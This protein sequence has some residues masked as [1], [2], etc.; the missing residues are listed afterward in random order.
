MALWLMAILLTVTGCDP[1]ELINKKVP[2][3]LK[4]VMADGKGA[5]K[6]GKSGLSESL[7]K[8]SIAIVT[9][10]RNSVHPMA[11]DIEFEAKVTIPK[12]KGAP[13]AT[14]VWTLYRGAVKKGVQIGRG[15]FIKKK[16]DAGKYR[17]SAT[18]LVKDRKKV[19]TSTFR[20]ANTT[21]GRITDHDGGPF[22]GTELVITEIDKT[23]PLFTA[24]SDK[25]GRFSIEVPE[26]GYYKL[27]PKK[28]GFSFQP[29]SRVVK[30]TDPPIQQNFKAVKG[31]ITSIKFTEDPEGETSLDAVCPLQQSYVTFSV[32]SDVK[33]KSVTVYLVRVQEGKEQSIQ[34]DDVSDNPSLK[35]E[36][37]PEDT[38]LKLQVPSV[39]AVGPN[40]TTYRLRLTVQDEKGRQFSAEASEPLAYN[41]MKCFRLTL[42]NGVSQQGNDELEDAIKSYKLME[43]LNKKV[44]D[45]T[46]FITFMEQSTFNRGLAFLALAMKEKPDSIERDSMLKRAKDDFDRVLEND[47][48]DLDAKLFLGL[49]FQLAGRQDYA[50]RYYKTIIEQEP[51]YPG[52]RELRALA[53]LKY[54]E[55]QQKQI[56]KAFRAAEKEGMRELLGRLAQVTMLTTSE[57]EVLKRG[58]SSIIE[59]V[60]VLLKIIKREQKSMERGLLSVVD[61]LTEAIA[62]DPDNQSLRKSRREALEMVYDLQESEV[63]VAT[64]RDN[65]RKLLKK[66]SIHDHMDHPALKAPLADIPRRETKAVLD[67]KKSIRK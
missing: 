47:K 46:P 36:V 9:P 60:N 50:G 67:L 20:V 64:F 59:R 48:S 55:I 12:I 53:R 43:T 15:E 25:D 31:Q 18:L 39:M 19:K 10:K 14:V 8:V 66:E 42:A 63:D 2:E 52:V 65:L 38:V 41:I 40:E 37:S 16:L 21:E 4:D 28:E 34:M 57:K 58:S 22:P 1:K 56:K 45:P 24:K 26:E 30:F 44:N 6:K 62:G 33:P 3:P 54:W 13:K 32:K 27:M 61:D 17:V 49:T 5:S 11:K 23:A 35:Q 29:F 7:D 51:R